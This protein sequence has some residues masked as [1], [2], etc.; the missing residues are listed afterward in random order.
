MTLRDYHLTLRDVANEQP[1]YLETVFSLGN[2]H[3]GVRAN[4][5]ISGNPIT[6]TLINGF[7]ETAPLPMAK[8]GSVMHRNTKRFSICQICGTSTS[9]L[10]VV[11][12]SR[13]AS[14]RPLVS[15]S[16]LAY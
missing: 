6:G 4:D 10:V 15:I 1:E 3:F 5:P 12:S 14:G 7:Y 2:G 11:I 13:T 9:Q 8:Q 16:A